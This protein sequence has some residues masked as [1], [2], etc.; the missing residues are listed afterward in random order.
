MKDPQV[1]IKKKTA[2]VE[3]QAES[4]IVYDVEEDLFTD[5]GELVI[6]LADG[7]ENTRIVKT[8]LPVTKRRVT[9]YIERVGSLPVVPSDEPKKG[10]KLLFKS[11]KNLSPGYIMQ[12]SIGS[13]KPNRV[14]KI[15]GEYVFGETGQRSKESL[16]LPPFDNLGQP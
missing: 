4:Y 11:I 9:F 3:S 8:S 1:I 10:E 13:E 7:S 12:G 6:P 15:C 5:S 14:Y 2:Q 16:P